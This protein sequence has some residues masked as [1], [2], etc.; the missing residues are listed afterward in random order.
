MYFMYL[1]DLLFPITPSCVSQKIN[2]NN[3]TL[4]LVNDGEVTLTK[5]PSLTEIN[6][7]EIIFPSFQ[8]YPFAIYDDGFKNARYFL[9]KIESFKK[10]VNK[11]VTFKISRVTPD[12]KNLLWNTS[13]DVTV[14]DYEIIEDAD[15]YGFD[16]AI[17]LSLK[18]YRPFG[19]KQLTIKKSTTTT[20]KKSTTKATVSSTRKASTKTASKTYTVKSGDTLELIAKKHLGKSSRSN[21]IYKLNKTVIENTAKKHGK[22]S[23]SNGHWI[24]P[25]TKLK[26]PSK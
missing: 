16:I 25:G 19:T 2:S 4:N 12:N 13:M 7:D 14:E 21:E 9:D 11:P 23:S 24:W 26:L 22:K 20:T 10:Q 6:I 18:Q 3:K 17:K 8:E 1:G 5:T 15:K